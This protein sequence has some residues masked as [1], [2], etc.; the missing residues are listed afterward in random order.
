MFKEAW[1]TLKL[2]FGQNHLVARALINS[3]L[4]YEHLEKNKNTTLRKKLLEFSTKMLSVKTT[5]Q[6]YG[7]EADINSSE[8]LKVLV[9]KLPNFGINEWKKDAAQI[10]GDGREPKLE[11]FIKLVKRLAS[12][13][14]HTYSEVQSSREKREYP[15]KGINLMAVAVKKVNQFNQAKLLRMQQRRRK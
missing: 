10:Y 11:D 4:N 14:T 8:I 2:H 3:L 7:K 5:L 15:P 6:T 13:E 9:A 1:D 12:R